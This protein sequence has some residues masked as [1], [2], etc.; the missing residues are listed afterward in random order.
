MNKDTIELDR[1]TNHIKGYGIM[2]PHS[3]TKWLAEANILNEIIKWS[4]NYKSLA[5]NYGNGAQLARQVYKHIVRVEEENVRNDKFYIPF[6]NDPEGARQCDQTPIPRC[7][8]VVY[9]DIY[10]Q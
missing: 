4:D 6:E 10:W 3:Q 2:Y 7:D 1:D 9:L 5:T 8:R